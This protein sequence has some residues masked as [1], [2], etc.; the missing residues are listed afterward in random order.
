MALDGCGTERAKT[1]AVESHPSTKKATNNHLLVAFFLYLNQRL[2][3]ESEALE[4]KNLCVLVFS[5]HSLLYRD[6]VV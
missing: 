2:V 4:A 6:L 1:V 3:A 5:C